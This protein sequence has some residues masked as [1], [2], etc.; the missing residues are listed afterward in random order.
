MLP[1]PVINQ[2]AVKALLRGLKARHKK[3]VKQA[4]AITPD[5]FRKIFQ[6]VDFSEPLQL[7]AWVAVLMGF[8]LLLRASNLTPT[9]THAFDPQVNL[10]RADFRMHKGVILV[11]IKWTKKLQYI[12]KKL[13]I[14]VI[15]FTDQD[16][17]AVSWF[18]YMVKKI[19][20]PPDA[21]AFCVPVKKHKAV[22]YQPLSYS[23]L[24][25]LLKQW[26][27]KANLQSHSMTSHC[28]RR[29]GASWLKQSGVPDSIVRV[30]G[31][32][33]S[34]AF[35]TYIDSALE[36]RLEAMEQFAREN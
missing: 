7:V 8:H 25:R 10:C 31:D 27:E 5:M 26:S 36:T 6:V 19:P 12:E 29:G 14:P 22:V 24:A 23:Q 11:N 32:W 17:S 35:L 28:L 3:P 13:L 18:Q 15:P 16:I 30:L 1:Q 20:A 9:S 2:Y 33:R 4:V 34:F 21:P